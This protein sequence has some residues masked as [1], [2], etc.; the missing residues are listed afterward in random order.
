VAPDN[1]KRRL[2]NTLSRP[3]SSTTTTANMFRRSKPQTNT[4]DGRWTA[5]EHARFLQGML[6]HG[7]SWTRIAKVVKTRTTVQVRSH[8]QKYEAKIEKDKKLAQASE[9]GASMDAMGANQSAVPN[10]TMRY[11]MED[12]DQD[13]H[14]LMKEDL[15][16]D[17]PMPVP[18]PHQ[19]MSAMGWSEVPPQI[20]VGHGGANMHDLGHS[21]HDGMID[22]DA[23]FHSMGSS[24]SSN[25]FDEDDVWQYLASDTFSGGDPMHFG[26][27]LGAGELAPQS[28]QSFPTEG[29]LGYGF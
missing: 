29:S 9:M 13:H 19:P 5:D 3:D 27:D 10:L 4:R 14:D 26:A 20:G 12:D 25:S 21:S 11:A 18:P 8:A 15:G 22:M 24:Q 28:F 16:F 17:L 6:I 2:A 1:K 23:G 7:R